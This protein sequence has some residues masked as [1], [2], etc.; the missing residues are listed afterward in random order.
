MWYLPKIFIFM[1]KALLIAFISFV[2]L[3]YCCDNTS[4]TSNLQKKQFIKDYI[5]EG[6]RLHYNLVW[7]RH[8]TNIVTES[9]YW[10][11]SKGQKEISEYGEKIFWNFKLHSPYDTLP[12][13]RTH[14][15]AFHK[16]FYQLRTKGLLGES[17]SLTSSCITRQ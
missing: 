6:K 11:F 9:T 8:G 2:L 14:L 7:H 4:W 3:Y 13:K 16:Q 1:S 17:L 5:L 15:I 12:Q 10:F